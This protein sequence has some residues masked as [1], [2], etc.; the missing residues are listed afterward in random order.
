MAV[1]KSTFLQYLE[2]RKNYNVVTEDISAWKCLKSVESEKTFNL[3]DL[4]YSNPE[5]HQFHFQQVVLMSR[6]KAL[7]K[8]LP[9][10][11][12]N[13][14]ERSILSNK[15]V[16]LK[17]RNFDE[18]DVTILNNW[19][20]TLLDTIPGLVP[21]GIVYLRSKP[22]SCLSRMKS[23]ARTEETNVKLD[24]L[25]LID[26]FYE[27]WLIEKEVQLHPKIVNVP[28]LV[29]DFDKVS[30]EIFEESLQEIEKFVAQ[31]AN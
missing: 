27:K 21:D 31:L 3:L 30:D 4:A 26:K 15:H 6:I 11:S 5:K 19:I 16:F 20:D 13:F 22:T 2:R 29:L 24:Y 7:T 14:F 28:I 9:Q 1:G 25:A 8:N 23:R 12:I 10:N 17:A 18:L